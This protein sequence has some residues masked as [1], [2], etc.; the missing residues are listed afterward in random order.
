M[1]LAALSTAINARIAADTA[2]GGLAGATNPL[3]N[4]YY[5]DIAPETVQAPYMVWTIAVPG[6][7]DTFP[8]DGVDALVE[9]YIYTDRRDGFDGAR[10]I[11]DRLYGNG[12]A[13]DPPVPTYGFHRHEP[14][15][16]GFGATSFMFDGADS[17]SDE[18]DRIWRVAFTL[19]MWKNSTA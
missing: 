18:S 13:H 8:N 9:F 16:S 4:G 5:Y 2:D 12:M 3:L 1:N 7:R 19:S 11:I 17:A 14:E 6:P 10:K 15:I